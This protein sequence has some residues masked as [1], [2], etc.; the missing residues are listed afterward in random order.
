MPPPYNPCMQKARARRMERVGPS[1]I[2]ELLKLGS[3]P[4]V[5]SF[6]GGYP[7]ATHFP[8]EQLSE[9]YQT[10]LAENSREV[11]QYTVSNGIPQLREQIS[12]RMRSDGVECDADNI[13][14]LHG[15]QQGLDLTA[16]LLIERGDTIV[17]ENPTFLGGM[18]AFNPYEPTYATV[19]LDDDGLDTAALERLLETTPDVR[20][21][22]TV[23]DFHNPA[24]VTMS[25]ARRKHL[26]E[27]ANQYD[28]VVLEDSPYR[29]LR[30]EGERLPSLKSLDTQ[31]RVV[32]LG[33]FSK[34]LV[35]GLRLGW[36]VASHELT[37]E[38][39]LL[40]LAVDT[41]CSTINMHAVS[42]YLRQHDIDAHIQTLRATYRRKRDVMLN[43]IAREFPAEIRYTRPQ[44]GLFTWLTFPDGF[45]AGDFLKHRAIP[46][47]KVAYVPGGPFFAHG[48]RANHARVSY[49]TQPDAVIERGIAAL[50]RAFKRQF[51]T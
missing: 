20:L 31:G 30:F 47:A 42:M 29:E 16:K 3:D 19:P 36:A 48:Q 23:P 41:Q 6:G 13:L 34:I 28:F 46:E 11:L 51:A 15:S 4:S 39:G 38:L 9:I 25:L 50:G 49:S 26:I 17:V 33:S 22:Y 18:V 7:D 37:Q 12:A 2:R 5:V 8:A 45:D 14:I 24:G 43:A 21:L 32:Y 35:P 1:A 27:L 40:K 10:A 44:G